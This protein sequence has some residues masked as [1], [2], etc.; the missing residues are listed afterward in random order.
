[1]RKVI[2]GLRY[3]TEKATKIGTAEYHGSCTDFQYWEATLYRTPRS[4]RFFLAGHGG[5]MSR[6]SQSIGQNQWGG[7]EDLIPMSHGEAL[8]WAEQHLDADEIEKHF[9]DILEDA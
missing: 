8:E 9:G 5:P 1:M 2:N 7:G 3:D 4:N 6:F